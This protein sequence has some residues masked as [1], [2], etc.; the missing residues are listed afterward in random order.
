MQII[1]A[2]YLKF[3]MYQAEILLG[4]M[5]AYAPTTGKTFSKC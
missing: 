1:V 3:G 2:A 4:G 5:G